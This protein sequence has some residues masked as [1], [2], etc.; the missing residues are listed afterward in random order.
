MKI[1]VEELKNLCAKRG[2][3]L[4]QLLDQAGVSKNAYYSLAR[5]ETVLPGSIMR[6]ATRLGVKASSFLTEPEPEEA[7]IKTVLEDLERIVGRN[8]RA[9]RDNVR[10]T[11][12]LLQEE[13]IE[14]LRRALARGRKSDFHV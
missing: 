8:K 7:G 5:K 1:S 2:L 6:I 11:L 4:N 3:S 9:D 14:R 13:P 10:H 12:L